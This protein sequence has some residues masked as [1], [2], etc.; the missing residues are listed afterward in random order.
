MARSD[1]FAKAA[2]Y[3]ILF[4]FFRLSGYVYC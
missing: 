2:G 4:S 3:T 1:L